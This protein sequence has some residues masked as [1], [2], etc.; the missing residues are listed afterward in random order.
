MV[1]TVAYT[2]IL[3]IVL[4]PYQAYGDFLRN[5]FRLSE[6]GYYG[7]FICFFLLAS[8]Y[9]YPC[10][11]C[12]NSCLCRRLLTITIV[13]MVSTV[14]YTLI[15]SLLSLCIIRQLL[16]GKLSQVKM[17]DEVIC[18]S[19]GFKSYDITREESHTETLY[20]WIERDHNM[21]R[22]TFFSQKTMEWLCFALK[23]A[24]K[25]KGNSIRRWKHQEYSSE[26]F[27]SRN[28]NRLGRYI[29]IG[30]WTLFTNGTAVKPFTILFRN[31]EEG[32]LYSETA[33][34]NK[35]TT[36]E[37]KKATVQEKDGIIC[38]SEGVSF[39]QNELLSRSVV[40]SLL[41]E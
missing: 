31:T 40:G 5:Y 27:C 22:R 36:R 29:I 20:N 12:I 2:L 4:C 41:E 16:A 15:L 7:H 25:V 10:L 38:I 39:S 21:I 32:L 13:F 18:F 19:V 1:S 6:Q 35:W 26:F 37:M 3:S 23:E 9:Y 33:R 17:V 30:G 24:S 14:S 34:R 28:F 8:S 11:H